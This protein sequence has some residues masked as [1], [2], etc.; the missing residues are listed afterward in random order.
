VV[1]DHQ[2][3]TQLLTDDT[4]AV[5]GRWTWDPWGNIEEAWSQ[6][7]TDLL[8]QGKPY[9]VALGEW[10]FNARWYNPERGNFTGRDVRKQ[11]WTP[12]SFMG[13]MVVI[14]NDQN[15]L[16]FRI[17]YNK[18]NPVVGTYTPQFI[19][20]I[21]KA[22]N[23]VLIK[24]IEIVGHANSETQEFDA[25]VPGWAG[26]G[27]SLHQNGK[28]VGVTVDAPIGD[29]KFDLGLL[30]KG[31]MSSDAQIW[32]KG[33]STAS[34][35]DNIAKVTSLVVPNTKVYGSS[36]PVGVVETRIKQFLGDIGLN[37]SPIQDRVYENGN[38][39]VGGKK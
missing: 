39:E 35:E 1:T 2:G 7:S 9:E 37:T 27:L 36:V 32:Y 8:Y 17:S 23:G 21:D 22:V 13:N 11:F 6:S 4:G 14:G 24:K 34:G 3:T 33:C 18:G 29:S 25:G 28:F 16:E 10:Y 31:K 19:A 26:H 5:L 15:G 30:L 20:A 12:Y 38:L